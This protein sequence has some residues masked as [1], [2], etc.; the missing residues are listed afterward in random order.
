MVNVPCQPIQYLV[1]AYLDGELDLVKNIE[2]EQHLSRCPACRAFYDARQRMGA[3]VRS[4]TTYF[5]APAATERRLTQALDRLEGNTLRRFAVAPK[6]LGLAASLAFAAVIGAGAAYW[7]AGPSEENR[8]AQEAVSNHVR[9][10]R[11]ASRM[12]DVSSSDQHTVK[13]WF[14]GKLNFS[15]PVLDLTGKGFALVGGRLDYLDNQPVAALVYRHR[16]HL[17]NLFVWPATEA[18]HRPL[19]SL[20]RQGYRVSHWSDGAMRYWVV[21][22]L[23]PADL[24]TFCDLLQAS[25]GHSR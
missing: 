7:T 22:D 21:S 11:V 20:A 4:G 1:D 13:P 14:N 3:D 18:G 23:N 16:Q 25:E 17:I 5:S 8:M 15:P 24:K 9:S 6:W 19:R 10:L 2:I 12:T